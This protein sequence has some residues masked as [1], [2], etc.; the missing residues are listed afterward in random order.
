MV[1]MG[2]DEVELAINY[3]LKERVAKY[4]ALE[5]KR[6]YLYLEFLLNPDNTDIREQLSLVKKDIKLYWHSF[7]DDEKVGV[8]RLLL[9]PLNED[10]EKFIH[11]RV[12]ETD[13]KIK[14][15]METNLSIIIRYL[16]DELSPDESRELGL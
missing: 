10:G 6:G 12:E 9:A 2:A 13:D 11:S 3:S 8:M 7:T 15:Y 5:Y 4:F 1:N 14:E 16:R